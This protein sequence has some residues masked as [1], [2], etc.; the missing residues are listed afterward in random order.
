MK[1]LTKILK[2]VGVVVLLLVIGYVAIE[3]LAYSRANPPKSVTDISSCLAWLKKPMGVY[4]ITSSEGVFYQ[5]TGPAGGVLAS[6]PAG[7][8]FDAEGKFIGW[9][10]D[11]GDIKQPPEL[12]ETGATRE[13]ITIEELNKRL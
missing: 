9:S 13:K 8:A 11:I 2:V 7:Y 4:R 10:A 1:R 5:I 3:R 12:F 6:G